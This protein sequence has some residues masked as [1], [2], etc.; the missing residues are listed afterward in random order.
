[1]EEEGSSI[2]FCEVKDQ[3]RSRDM[4]CRP[5]VDHWHRPLIDGE[6]GIMWDSGGFHM[7]L[8]PCS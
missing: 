7:M 4:I 2:E 5:S 3:P 1:M 6:S 8:V